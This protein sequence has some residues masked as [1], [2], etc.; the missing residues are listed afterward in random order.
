M[1]RSSIRRAFSLGLVL[2]AGAAPATHGQIME[3]TYETYQL[4]DFEV[5]P[6]VELDGLRA[7]LNIVINAGAGLAGNAAALAAFNRAAQQ[8]AGLFT[9]GTTITINANLANLGGG[10]V[11]GAAST[12]LLSVG[13]DTMRA[14]LQASADGDD[15]I[16]A[17]LPTAA[18]FTATL[19]GGFGL[20]GNIL[21]T[22]AALKAVGGFGNLDGTFGATDA[23]L[24]FNTQFAFD[25]DN[26][27]GVSPG[28]VDFETVAAHEIGHALGFASVVDSVDQLVNNGQ[29]AN[30]SPFLLDFFRFANGTANDPSNAASFTTATRFLSP[31]GSPITDFITAVGAEAVENA[32]STGAFTGDGRQ[33]SHWKD[34]A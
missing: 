9:D 19:P 26:S 12:V 22:K 18:Q 23:T 32:M 20:T 21:G 14:A 25:F 5:G 8:W 13:H 6:L 17:S 7:D 27:N 3:W 1:V 34:N 28:L 15:G 10:T 16:V 2:W 4:E 11:I 24:T 33:A 31:G 29:A 30:V